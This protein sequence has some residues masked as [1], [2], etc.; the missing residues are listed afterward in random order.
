MLSLLEFAQAVSMDLEATLARIWPKPGLLLRFLRQFPQDESMSLVTSSL[1]KGDDHGLEYA[2]HSLK[3]LS[4]NL[5]LG[6]VY[7]DSS[8]LVKAVGKKTMPLLQRWQPSWRRAT[9]RQWRPS[10]SWRA[11]AQG[12][13]NG[14]AL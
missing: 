3:G 5:G 10:L 1:A 14:A 11:D 6:Q 12:N 4:A 13:Q 9:G 2:A 7:Q 8:R